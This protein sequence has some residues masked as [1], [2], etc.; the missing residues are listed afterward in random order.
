MHFAVGTIALR[1]TEFNS[2]HCEDKSLGRN[3][4]NST[5]YCQNGIREVSAVR[6]MQPVWAASLR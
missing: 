6:P 4:G 5:L 3:Q 2:L 1:D